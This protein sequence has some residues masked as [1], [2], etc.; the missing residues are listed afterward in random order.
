MS[1]GGTQFFGVGAKGKSFAFVVDTSGSMFENARY[2]RCQMELIESIRSLTPDQKYFVVFFNNQTH[3]MSAKRLILAKPDFLKQTVPWI[4]TMQPVGT[5]EPWPALLMS[6][7]M[8]P[9][10][11]YFLTDGAFDEDVVE[12]IRAHSSTK[13]IPIHTIAFEGQSGECSSRRLRESPAERTAT[14]SS[15]GSKSYDDA[16]AAEVNALGRRRRSLGIETFW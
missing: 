16:A 7:R 12:K 8:R 5:T 1:G 4:Q 3:P 13:K 14:F 2:Q 11:V 9:D 6:L 10:A 15:R